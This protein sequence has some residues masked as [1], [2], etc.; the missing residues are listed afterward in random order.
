MWREEG[1]KG[2]RRKDDGETW[3]GVRGGVVRSERRR[4][5][6]LPG[7]AVTGDESAGSD[8]RGQHV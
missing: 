8:L 3:K 2:G 6:G 1:E 4:A 5:G 7:I